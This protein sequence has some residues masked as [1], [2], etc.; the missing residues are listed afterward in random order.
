MALQAGSRFW[1]VD[2]YFSCQRPNPPT[3]T[4]FSA[5]LLVRP[6]QMAQNRYSKL[7][8]G[9][10][11]RKLLVKPRRM[12][13]SCCKGFR[14]SP[15][16]WKTLL[17]LR[18]SSWQSSGPSYVQTLLRPRR[19]ISQL[20]GTSARG[21]PWV[22]RTIQ[23]DEFPRGSLARLSRSV[24]ASLAQCTLDNQPTQARWRTCAAAQLDYLPPEPRSLRVGKEVARGGR[25]G[26]PR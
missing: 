12:Q 20:P 23:R 16:A 15:E 6:C 13:K 5:H 1:P 24:L 10:L 21:L 19:R 11:T 18:R 2:K 17:S 9:P 7:F 25:S 22:A 4:S 14:R 8:F 3:P 26:C